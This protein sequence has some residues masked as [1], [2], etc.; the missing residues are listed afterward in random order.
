MTEAIKTL[1]TPTCFK[2]KPEQAIN[3]STQTHIHA[4]DPQ[5]VSF[6]TTHFCNVQIRGGGKQC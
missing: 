1:Q 5:H 4:F 2:N 6:C 3:A